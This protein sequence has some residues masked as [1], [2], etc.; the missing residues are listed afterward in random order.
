MRFWYKWVPPLSLL[1]GTVI[2]LGGVLFAASDA[3]QANNRADKLV[4]RIA[5]IEVRDRVTAYRTAFRL[6]ARERADRAFAHSSI[7]QSM[8][9]QHISLKQIE[10]EQRKLEDSHG[11]PILNC[12]PNLKGFSASEWAPA[13]QRK[14]VKR[15]ELHQL[16]LEELGVCPGQRIQPPPLHPVSGCRR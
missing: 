8:E 5:M 4:K 12:D 11:I 3:R 13:Q 10:L 6:C 7:L 1:V 14:F 15:W 16:P 9:R 2:A